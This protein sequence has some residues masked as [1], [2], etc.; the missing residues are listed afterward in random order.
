MALVTR[1]NLDDI[2]GNEVVDFNVLESNN[3]IL[4]NNAAHL[5][6]SNSYTNMQEVHRSSGG[7]TALQVRLDADPVGTPRLAINAD[8]SLN[9]QGG[10]SITNVGGAL[11]INASTLNVASVR[12]GAGTPAAPSY[13]FSTDTGTGLYSP[14]SQILGVAVGGIE[15]NRINNQGEIRF[16]RTN[17]RIL[18][19]TT[20]DP[21]TPGERLMQIN[22]LTV[23]PG[24]L[25]AASATIN[26]PTQFNGAVAD[27]STLTVAGAATMSST[28]TVNGAINAYGGMI[29]FEGSNVVNIQWRGDLGAL[30]I[31]Y[32]NGIYTVGLTVAGSSNVTGTQTVGGR[33]VVGGYD[34]GW[35]SNFGMGTTGTI[36]NG[37]FYQR[38]DGGARCL[39]VRDF[40]WSTGVVGSALVQRDGS[41]YI[42]ANFIN[43]TAGVAG[44]KPDYVVGMAG[45]D[46]FLRY[47]PRSALAPVNLW[48]I[49]LGINNNYGVPYSGYYHLSTHANITGGDNCGDAG[50]WMNIV[51][52]GG[53]V[54]WGHWND[55]CD[56]GLTWG[57]GFIS[58]GQGVLTQGSSGRGW[59]SWTMQV[60]FIP[61]PNYTGA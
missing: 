23:T 29:H 47:W 6:L 41:G 48:S 45:G 60:T 51:V 28:L 46:N 5:T 20:D 33:L 52:N 54:A 3:E 31:P 22:A 39:D 1:F 58:A 49:T 25:Y 2:L 26:G 40:T 59:S 11:T 56:A 10:S 57:P 19:Y 13:A 24:R 7:A 30:Y 37:Y 55:W 27:A 53:Q 14:S 38:G 32:G 61:T 15:V 17:A 4:G 12:A 34:A 36:T 42:N 18:A 43:M 8:G 16:N 9:W 21:A 35:Q 44:G 50:G